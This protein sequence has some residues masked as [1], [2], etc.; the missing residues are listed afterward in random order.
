[1]AWSPSGSCSPF[2]SVVAFAVLAASPTAPAF[3][4]TGGVATL[5]SSVPTATAV[6]GP[7][8][9]VTPVSGC[10]TG[11]NIVENKC[12]EEMQQ[13]F[14]NVGSFF[15]IP[16]LQRP[17]S[18]D[19]MIK[20]SAPA[21]PGQ[22]RL[23]GIS[24]VSNRSVVYTGVGALV[25]SRDTPYLPTAVQLTG[26][27]HLQVRAVA[28]ATCV[29]M[30]GDAI[31]LD[32]TQAA[33]LVLRFSDP[34]DTNFT[35]VAADTDS[36]DHP[37]DFMSRDLGE[38]WYRPDPLTSPLDWKFTAYYAPVSSRPELPWSFVKSMYR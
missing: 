36:N 28:G 17:T 9:P 16:R 30:S 13:R 7:S 11:G 12:F 24:F 18:E 14:L 4:A 21:T 31:V 5:A 23:E 29:D 20:Y 3:A 33:W 15:D 34:L 19:V 25:T 27:Q 32:A 38:V 35:G 1:M 37:C 22:Y 26:I 2:A 8:I 10:A 6:R